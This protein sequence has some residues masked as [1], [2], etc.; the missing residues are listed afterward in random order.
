MTYSS[1]RPRTV[2]FAHVTGKARFHPGE[3]EDNFSFPLVGS[4]NLIIDTII[5]QN[6]LLKLILSHEY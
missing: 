1:Q 4:V 2:R 6:A 3:A 5:I